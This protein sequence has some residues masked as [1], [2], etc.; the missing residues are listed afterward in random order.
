MEGFSKDG[1]YTLPIY[2]RKGHIT[3][4]DLKLRTFSSIL[5]NYTG[6]FQ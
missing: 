2:P 5:Q 3:P 1:K 6:F 4:Q